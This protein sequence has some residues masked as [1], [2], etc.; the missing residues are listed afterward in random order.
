MHCPFCSCIDTQVKDSRVA[1]DGSYI[2]RRRSCPECGNRFTTFERVELKE[3]FVKKSN[4]VIEPFVREKLLR[5]IKLAC[6]KREITDER[7]EKIVSAIQR[8]L[9]TTI[10]S[11]VSTKE[12]GSL[13]MEIL[14]N[15]DLV[16]YIRFASVYYNFH[17]K[18]DFLKF[19]DTI[20]K[21]VEN[22]K[23]KQQEPIK[24]KDML[25]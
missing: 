7:I 11:E 25:F 2:K 12:I 19:I 18:D 3:I 24:I 20:K 6:K 15:L 1:E 4:G 17:N 13:V 5:S 21:E 22:E 10:D 23:T 8:R 14:S 9:E 16:A